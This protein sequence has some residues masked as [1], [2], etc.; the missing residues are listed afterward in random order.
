MNL[1]R[2]IDVFL[3]GVVLYACFTFGKCR[4]YFMG[5]TDG[6]INGYMVGYESFYEKAFFNLRD[7]IDALSK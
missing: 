1:G 4:G 3:I 6:Q 5:Y 2:I 7:S